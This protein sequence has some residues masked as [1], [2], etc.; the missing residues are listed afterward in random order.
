M[1][2]QYFA[3]DKYSSEIAPNAALRRQRDSRAGPFCIRQVSPYLYYDW[4]RPVSKHGSTIS[5]Q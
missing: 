1:K 2:A 3:P 5:I 4:P